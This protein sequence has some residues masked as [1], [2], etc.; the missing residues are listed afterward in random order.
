MSLI[1]AA[2]LASPVACSSGGGGA[3]PVTPLTNDQLDDPTVCGSCHVT[4]YQAWSGS[5]HAYAGDDPVFLAM[6]ARGQ[7]VTKGAL[8]S[9][10]VKCHAPLALARGLTTD[11]TNLGALPAKTRGVTCYVCHA[12][13]DVGAAHDASFHLAT[14]GK[15]RAAITD[16]SPLAP[17]GS[18]YSPLHDRAQ[19]ASSTM[20][21]SCHQLANGHGLTLQATL[22]EWQGSLYAQPQ[23]TLQL[24]CGNCH[25]T[26]S[27][28]PASNQAGAPSRELHDHSMV[29]VD[30]ALSSFAGADVQRAGVQAALD[31]ALVTQLC[32]KPGATGGVDLT[33]SLDDA[34]AGHDFPSGAAYHRRA[35]IELH[36]FRGT[37]AAETEVW[38]DGVVGAAEAV[39]DHAKTDAAFSW[40][41][42][43]LARSDGSATH[44]L[45][46]ATTLGGSLLLPAVTNVPSDPRFYHA[47]IKSY[48]IPAPPV[49]RITMVVKMRPIDV[50]L[51]DDL[52]GSGDLDPAV[53]ARVATFTLAGSAHTWT[54]DLGYRCVP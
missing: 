52:V 34:F 18:S 48:S 29:G 2:A 45:W 54:S 8:G 42:Q 33:A 7:R 36:A 10:C 39:V 21:G 40:F 46:D 31:T 5:M 30:V 43:T 28:G 12:I 51:V 9:F 49:D 47:S 19:L 4:H 22:A 16:P 26:A 25:M 27:T 23:P 37:G 38:S 53:G 3:P 11:G 35:W 15:L 20:C 14:D 13:D 50:D 1:A 32:T 17:H 6:N 44:M 24:T 41:G